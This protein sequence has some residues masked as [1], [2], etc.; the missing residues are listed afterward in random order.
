MF[1]SLITAPAILSSSIIRRR[2]TVTNTDARV[3]CSEAS[4]NFGRCCRYPL[5]VSFEEMG[6]NFIITPKGFDAK[7]CQVRVC[8]LCK[9]YVN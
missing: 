5:F 4:N 8:L 2:R 1:L 7:M 6:W 9:L 3:D